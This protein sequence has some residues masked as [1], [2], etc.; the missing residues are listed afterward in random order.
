MGLGVRLGWG[1]Q[2][3]V[4]TAYSALVSG[5]QGS[6]HVG[7]TVRLVTRTGPA[8]S[9]RASRPIDRAP[10]DRGETGE[11]SADRRQVHEETQGGGH[12]DDVF[13]PGPHRRAFEGV[14]DG[15]QAAA[16]RTEHDVAPEVVDPSR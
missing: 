13:K 8:R 2:R 4:R 6:I 12:D 7:A 11:Y 15:G 5:A 3:H 10:L 16:D 14:E 9:C 1:S